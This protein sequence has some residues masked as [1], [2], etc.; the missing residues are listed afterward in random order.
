MTRLLLAV[1]VSWLASATCLPCLA[2]RTQDVAPPGI[3]LTVAAAAEL[4]PAITEVA[5]AF[6]DKTGN[7]VRVMSGESASLYQRI[8]GGETFDAFFPADISDVRR[9]TASGSAMRGSTIEYARDELAV[10]IS[11]MVGAEFPPGNPLLGLRNKAIV[12]IAMADPKRTT[13]GRA[14]MQAFRAARIY[15]LALRRKLLVGEDIARTAQLL[16][17]GNAS[18]AVLPQSAARDLLAGARIIPIAPKLYQ[19]LRMEAVVLARSKHRR[20]AMEFL[21]FAASP[22]GQA[23]FVRHG[24][25]AVGSRH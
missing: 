13:S 7:H 19:P 20:E 1:V 14:T 12:P 3:E 22:P 10:C 5:R 21:R 11:P 18:V 2:E 6:E 9:L 25:L 15:D 8:R 4:N 17:S 16:Q 23:I 24:F